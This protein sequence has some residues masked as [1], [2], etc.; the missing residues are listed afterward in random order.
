MKEVTRTWLS[1]RFAKLAILILFCWTVCGAFKTTLN[2]TL[3]SAIKRNDVGR[4][5]LVLQ[6][7]ADPNVRIDPRSPQPM[8][9]TIKDR[10]QGKPADTVP[11][12]ILAVERSYDR[13]NGKP[14]LTPVLHNPTLVQTMLESGADINVADASGDSALMLAVQ[15]DDAETLKLLLSRRADPNCRN[16]AGDTPLIEA[17]KH[18]C[19]YDVVAALLEGGADANLKETGSAS[20]V[21]T[22]LLGTWK[23]VGRTP[24]ILAVSSSDNNTD[25]IEVLLAHGALIDDAD[26]EGHTALMWAT[27]LDN[28]DAV[29]LLTERGANTVNR[30]ASRKAALSIAFDAG[31]SLDTMSLLQ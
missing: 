25:I 19:S 28:E 16:A 17:L 31:A 2:Y 11:A 27:Y 13:P 15:Q 23:A 24:L 22:S 7:G 29:S 9:R 14:S 30:D 18:N 20:V 1:G 5:A 6:L 4:V 26:S 3:V 21:P 12:L 10:V 8:W